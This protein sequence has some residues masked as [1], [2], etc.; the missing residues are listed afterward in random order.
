MGSRTGIAGSRSVVRGAGANSNLQDELESESDSSN[1][2]DESLSEK[3][4]L[5]KVLDAGLNLGMIARILRDPEHLK[6]VLNA[7]DWDAAA[8]GIAASDGAAPDLRQTARKR[9]AEAVPQFLVPSAATSSLKAICMGAADALGV[10]HRKLVSRGAELKVGGT[11][12]KVEKRREERYSPFVTRVLTGA[13]GVVEV[14]AVDAVVATVAMVGAGGSSKRAR[15][16][17]VVE[18]PRPSASQFPLQLATD[19]VLGA[20]MVTDAVVLPALSEPIVGWLRAFFESRPRFL[21][22][23]VQAVNGGEAVETLMQRQWELAAPL[24]TETFQYLR[25]RGHFGRNTWN[26]AVDMMAGASKAL[27]SP[28]SLPSEHSVLMHEWA[29]R[30]GPLRVSIEFH[31]LPPAVRVHLPSVGSVELIQALHSGHVTSFA[32]A[33]RVKICGAHQLTGKFGV[34]QS[35]TVET[36]RYRV[37]LDAAQDHRSVGVQPENLACANSNWHFARPLHHPHERWDATVDTEECF[38]KM[39]QRSIESLIDGRGNLALKVSTPAYMIISK[40]PVVLEPGYRYTV[41]ALL[42]GKAT[43]ALCIEHETHDGLLSLAK[44]ETSPM[45][46]VGDG[47]HPYSTLSAFLETVG[48]SRIEPQLRSLGFNTINILLQKLVLDAPNGVATLVRGGISEAH[49]QTLK[50]FCAA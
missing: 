49:A 44:M 42:Q 46:V 9:R 47:C 40:S 15:A 7:T 30:M 4:Q 32:I 12:A 19:G 8:E 2:G 38:S 21:P 20:P 24:L 14:D 1:S 31:S 11:P 25:Q 29:K 45:G 17:A 6:L 43:V 48:L 33:D 41:R 3:E 10:Q 37:Q 50:T 16:G 39:T 36:G 34:V 22:V 13:L 35:F 18:P 26:V 5:K 23:V 28:V 27:R